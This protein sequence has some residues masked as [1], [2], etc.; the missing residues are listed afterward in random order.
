MNDN[1][2]TSRMDWKKFGPAFLGTTI[3]TCSK[4][5]EGPFSEPDINKLSFCQACWD[6]GLVQQGTQPE[7]IVVRL[8]DSDGAPFGKLTTF[9]PGTEREMECV[10]ELAKDR[11]YLS[12]KAASGVAGT[13]TVKRIGSEE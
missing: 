3:G 6:E 8:T 10:V 5:G 13:I 12:G 1:D 7:T 2:T 4:H 11:V 9:E